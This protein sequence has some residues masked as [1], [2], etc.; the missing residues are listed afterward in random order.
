VRF[1]LDRFGSDGIG[2][3]VDSEVADAPRALFCV[4]AN[5]SERDHAA[6]TYNE[7]LAANS[8]AEMH[9]THALSEHRRGP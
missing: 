2:V 1:R 8:L 6:G 9:R 3:P 7:Q 4:S 5:A